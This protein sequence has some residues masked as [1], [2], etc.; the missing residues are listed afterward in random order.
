[1]PNWMFILF[2]VI[3]AAFVGGI[4]NH[5]AI[6]M[7]FHPRQPIHLFGRR[8]P[9]TPG[10]IPKR[11]SDI[12]ASLGE[13]VSEYLVTSDGLRVM[14]RQPEVQE[15]A[16]AGLTGFLDRL[17]ADDRTLCEWAAI[18]SPGRSWLEICAAWGER[19]DTLT[20]SGI[21]YGLAGS[22]WDERPLSEFLSAGQE[23][24][25]NR[26][27]GKAASA[28]LLSIERELLSSGGQR[29]L[30]RMAKE[31]VD[32]SKG[33]MGVMA[34]IFVDEDK[35]VTRITPLLAE[36]LRSDKV[37]ETVTLMLERKLEECLSQ[38]PAELL[39][40]WSEGESEP[41]DQI[42]GLA[43]SWLQWSRRLERW[44]GS[45]PIR[46]LKESKE[47]W[48]PYV[49]R[50]VDCAITLLDRNLDKVVR[51]ARLQDVVRSQVGQFPIERLETIILSVSGKE[52]RAI[53]WLG[54]LLGG[55]IG[56]IQSLLLLAIGS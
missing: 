31:F 25:L 24:S 6:K 33:F 7:L 9:F 39:R 34:A 23:E 20:E 51:A 28:I 29:M 48:Q 50:I 54:A 4:T 21:R 13:V 1:M 46:W 12:A 30:L 22:G 43:K 8:V 42:L 32:R 17:L 52:F 55:M 47:A 27:A 18:A 45:R 16:T 15:Q 38:P 49:P 53:T 5:F 14:L 40:A 2:S 3:V 41:A 19:L 35:L 44:G 11:K 37:Q 36:Q 10:L 26:L 56:L